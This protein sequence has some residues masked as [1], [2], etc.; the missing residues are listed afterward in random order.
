[1][2]MLV[3]CLP[4]DMTDRTDNNP[5]DTGTY[6]DW[7]HDLTALQEIGED[8][9][10]DWRTQNPHSPRDYPAVRW[11][12]ENGY[13]HIRWI[14]REKHDM[15]TQEFFVLLTSA[16]GQEGYKWHIDE[17]ATIGLAKTYLDDRVECRNWR[18][19][20]METNRSRLNEILRRFRVKYG[21]AAIAAHAND[22]T[23]QTDLYETFKQVVKGLRDDLNSTESA[24]K[25]LRAGHRF[26]EWLERSGRTEYDP[27]AGLEAEFRWEFET[28]P[29]PLEAQQVAR[30]WKTAET[31]EERILVIGYCVW[32]LRTKELPAVHVNQLHFDQQPP[33]VSFNEPDRKN[34]LGEVSLLY[35]IDALATVL[36]E[37]ARNP[38]WNGYLFPGDD[39]TPYLCAKQARSKF[40]ALCSRAGVT[41]DGD[42][43]TPKHGRSFY[44]NILAD[45][46]ADLLEMIANLAEE[47]AA[48][49]V[50]SIRDRY[51]T[52]E[53]RDR[54]RRILFEY[55]IQNILPDDAY[56]DSSDDTDFDTSL[57]DF[58]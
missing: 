50:E 37:R 12:N 13:S 41:I 39:D 29:T 16:G 56:T 42:I 17:V 27:I 21:D 35:G 51:L 49:D 22:P 40:K 46:E 15:G 6:R 20:T 55:R 8:L 23:L 19:N 14:L 4:E 31:A 28:D 33:V 9:L 10:D 44:Y 58:T 48:K 57:D 52:P 7:A 45:A 18:E 3:G 54:Y 30:L 5:G 1:M 38:G 47:Q 36:D 2:N 24:Y 53:R 26:T 43:A 25:Y 32:G 11:L 34:G